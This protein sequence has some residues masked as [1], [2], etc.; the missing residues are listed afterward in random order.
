MPARMQASG[1][2]LVT[3]ASRGI[4]R[5][6]ALE[7]ARRGFDVVATMRNPAAGAALTV[8]PR[9]TVSRLD[10]DDPTTIDVPPGL[11]VLVNNA[12]IEGENLSLEDTPMDEWRRQFETNV[13][14]LVE[15]TRR[16]L[17]VLRA[18]GG[19]VVVNLTSAGLLVPMP[20]FAVYR[21]TKAAVT[22]LSE[23]L[24]AEVAPF[25]ISVIEVY[26]G[27]VETDMLAGSKRI[28]EA[29][30]YPAYARLAEHIGNLRGSEPVTPVVDA[31]RTIVDAI[32]ADPPP[33]RTS[34]DTM[35]KGLLAGW[36]TTPVADWHATFL[37]AFSLPR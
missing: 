37:S 23:S 11:R 17:P 14:G 12:A 2:A 6:V 7:L 36:S 16:A 29:H 3:G 28:P 24:R 19:G 4:G 33:H 34:C 21:A 10:V 27:P 31:A 26:P 15:V 1:T 8:E 18:N 25:G 32:Q 9:I 20:F 5:G 13:F 30:R 22:A 35:G